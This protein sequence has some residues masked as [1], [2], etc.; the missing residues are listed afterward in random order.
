MKVRTIT[1]ALLAQIG[2]ATSANAATITGYDITN[3]QASGTGLWS[4]SYSGTIT[5]AASGFSG[6]FDY[7]GGTG[8]LADGF[9]PTSHI[10]N[11]LFLGSNTRSTSITLFFD[12]AYKFSQIEI[13]G[14]ANNIANNI[15]GNISAFDVT[16]D[17]I[18]ETLSTTPFGPLTTNEIPQQNVNDR[19]IIA[20]TTLA[21]RVAKR[22]HIIKLP[23]YGYDECGFQIQHWR[24]L[25]R[26]NGALRGSYSGRAAALF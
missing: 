19:A 7:T 22:H 11:H 18:T 26:R 16:I 15:P 14:A 4:H 17:G 8:T 10:N 21:E 5:A 12:Q 1:L 6:F 13:F 25:S 9:V 23:D 20:G 2:L 24:N 3:T